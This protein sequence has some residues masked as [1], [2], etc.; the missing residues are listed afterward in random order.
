MPYGL[1]SQRDQ[2]HRIQSIETKSISETDN[3]GPLSSG[4]VSRING[5]CK[6]VYMPDGRYGMAQKRQKPLDLR[7]LRAAQERGDI[8]VPMRLQ[9]LWKHRLGGLGFLLVLDSRNT[10]GFGGVRCVFP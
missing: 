4:N 7:K 6:K 8:E 5:L 2:G 3:K 1:A 9:L 10:H